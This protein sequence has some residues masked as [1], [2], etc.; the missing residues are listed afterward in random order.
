MV[1]H[2]RTVAA[3][4]RKRPGTFEELALIQGMG[5]V[6]LAKYAEAILEI[7]SRYA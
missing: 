2:S 1:L 5:E 4:A 6:K 7:V 3:I